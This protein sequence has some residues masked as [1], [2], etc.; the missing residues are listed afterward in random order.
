[1]TTYSQACVDPQLFADWFGNESWSTWRVMDKALFGEPLTPGELAIFTELT[2]R[3]E[4]PTTPAKEAW[5]IMG[6]RSGKDLK[7]ASIAVYLATIGA[8]LH[9][10]RKRLQRGERG[11][12]QIL[13]V[14][15]DQ[16]SVA[17][18]YAKAF[19]E[20]PLLAPL[21]KRETADT[22]ELKNDLAIEITT[23]D[24]RRVRGRTVIAA[25]FDEV[26][27]WRNDNT[28]SP[29]LEVYRAV[30]PAMLTIP[31]A[32]LIGISSPHASRG[33]L[34]DKFSKHYGQNGDVL[35]ARAPTWKMNLT[36]TRET[37][38]IAST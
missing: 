31:N 25:I 12:V 38:E 6:R 4:A 15:R 23:N 18:R 20:Q 2:G 3:T 30:R 16:A 9:G 29:D 35:V 11:V 33:L 10:Y 5:L 36:V 22:L 19:F 17:F 32:M 1:V 34:Y 26:A 24:Q 14:D 21:L 28:I 37:E 27:H 8:E 13:A 7:A